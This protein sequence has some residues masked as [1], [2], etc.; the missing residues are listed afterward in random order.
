MKPVTPI[1]AFLLLFAAGCASKPPQD[2]QALNEQQ[3]QESLS[4]VALIGSFTLDGK[5][6]VSEDK[7]FIEGISKLTAKT[8]LFRARIGSSALSIPIP[9]TVEWAGDTPVITMTDFTIPGMGTFTARVLFYRH[10]YAGTWSAKNAGG[11]LFGRIAR[12]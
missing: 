2:A 3:F 10:R 5:P 11:Q 4:K 9:I 1:L 6:G 7:Y 8:W 12:Q